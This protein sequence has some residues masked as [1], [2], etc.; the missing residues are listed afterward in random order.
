MHKTNK[1]LNTE[2]RY[3]DVDSRGVGRLTWA[4]VSGWRCW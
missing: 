2:C 3:V 1:S 4:W